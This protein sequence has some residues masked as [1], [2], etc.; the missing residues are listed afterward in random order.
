M[1]E[2]EPDNA[3]DKY[4]TCLKKENNIVGH[5]PLGISGKFAKTISYFLSAIET[6]SCKI[7]ITGKPVILPMGLVCKCHANYF[8]LESK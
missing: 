1:S 8:F 7:A 5:L 2:G 4:A 6:N 3:E